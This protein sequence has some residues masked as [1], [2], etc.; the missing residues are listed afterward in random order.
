MLCIGGIILYHKIRL[1][2]DTIVYENVITTKGD[3]SGNKLTDEC[4]NVS[5]IELFIVGGDEISPLEHP[6][7]ALINYKDS[8]FRVG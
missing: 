6:W 8:G 1:K 5:N 2:S 7:L 4:D 3:G